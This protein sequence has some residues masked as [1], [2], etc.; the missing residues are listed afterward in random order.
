EWPAKKITHSLKT[1]NRRFPSFALTAHFHPLD[2][3][4]HILRDFSPQKIMIQQLIRD[5][6]FLFICLVFPQTGTRRLIND[7]FRHLEVGS[8][9]F[10]LAFKQIAQRYQIT[11]P[12]TV[13]CEIP[14]SILGSVG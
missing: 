3:F 13:L 14:H 10:Y 11:S 8:Q 5:S 6:H 9:F 4:L 7:L 1:W 12:I 2:F